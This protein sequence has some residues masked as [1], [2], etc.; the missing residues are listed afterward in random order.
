MDSSSKL[1]E[2]QQE[3]TDEF[4]KTKYGLT[5]KDIRADND[6]LVSWTKE[7]ILSLIKEATELLD[8]IDWKTHTNKMADGIT[9]NFLEEGVD[10]MKYL[11]GL[12]HIHGFSFD[13]I[14]EKF[15]DKSNVVQAKFEQ[16]IALK[17]LQENQSKYKIAAI[18][19]DGVIADWEKGYI[20]FIWENTMFVPKSTKLAKAEIPKQLMMET[21]EKFRL[22][23]KK[24]DL[25]LIPGAKEFIDWLKDQGYY[26]ILL[27]ARPYKEYSRIY[28]DTLHWLK[29]NNIQYDLII[30]NEKKEDF[31][32]KY[33]PDVKF[34]ID[35]E[36]GNVE[37]LS[38]EFLTFWKAEKPLGL[39]DSLGLSVKK[40]RLVQFGNFEDIKC[41]IEEI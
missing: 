8:E 19:I 2:I 6:K 34:V 31:L 3:F 20:N 37:K 5:V 30:W 36:R 33:F 15:I 7:Y 24:R 4:F 21:K 35:N 13:Q 27:T 10:V 26:V 39:L 1:Y 12:L 17:H 40:D 41:F 23:G 14:E 18:D 28:S 22:S 32:M 9:D 25:E 38:Q 11:F 16:A 29:K